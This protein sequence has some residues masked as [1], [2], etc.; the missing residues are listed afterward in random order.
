MIQYVVIWL[1]FSKAS[2]CNK[3]W[4]NNYV[5]ERWLT[6]QCVE[7]RSAK[8]M[9]LKEIEF[10]FPKE[11]GGYCVI[12]DLFNEPSICLLLLPY[13]IDCITKMDDMTASQR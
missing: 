13:T 11:K 5:T 6:T 4:G 10:I 9:K 3:K 8:E 12:F 2:Q 7:I 1:Y